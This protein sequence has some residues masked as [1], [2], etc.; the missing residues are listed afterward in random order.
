MAWGRIIN[1]LHLFGAIA[2]LTAA[3]LAASEYRGQVTF[4]GL[5]VPEQR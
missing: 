1:H 3:S 5:P 2:L 4:G